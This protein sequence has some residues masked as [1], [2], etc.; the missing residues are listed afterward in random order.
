MAYNFLG[1]FSSGQYKEL[2]A[3]CTTQGKDIQYRIN[4]LEGELRRVGYLT[5]TFDPATGYIK[6][7]TASPASSLVYKVLNAYTLLGGNPIKELPIRS[8]YEPIFLPQGTA[9]GTSKEWSNKR[10]VRNSFR[11]DAYIGILI[12]NLKSWVLES[13]GFKR[14]DLEFKL[15]KLVDLSDQYF[16]ERFVL[17]IVGNIPSSDKA[18][19]KSIPAALTAWADS[20]LAM[21]PKDVDPDKREQQVI[22]GPLSDMLSVISQE[23]ASTSHP[24]VSIDDNDIFGLTA[25]PIQY[26]FAVDGNQ[27][28]DIPIQE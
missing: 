23:V 19:A 20:R 9:S 17:K 6:E 3:F 2:A 24:S 18:T 16:M 27:G 15:K 10:I 12:D 7:V 13:V 5:V 4:Y 11:Y 1:T 14:E 25:G 28:D 22:L 26:T 8:I 21:I